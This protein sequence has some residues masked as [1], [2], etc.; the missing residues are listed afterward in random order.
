MRK[1]IEELKA[2]A[3]QIISSKSSWA[4][5][6]D[7]SYEMALH[8]AGYWKLLKEIEDLEKDLPM[9][10]CDKDNLIFK[11]VIASLAKK[12]VKDLEDFYMEQMT[13]RYSDWHP[14]ELVE[15]LK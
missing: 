9:S 12:S 15:V 1:P 10:D 4:N 7:G 11:I 5:T 2:K 8:E 6:T 13:D 3:D 14:H